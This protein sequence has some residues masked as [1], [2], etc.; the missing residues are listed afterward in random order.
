MVLYPWAA[1]ANKWTLVDR[2]W[3]GAEWVWICM[4]HIY[5]SNVTINIYMTLASSK[6]VPVSRWLQ[7]RVP[8]H[9]KIQ[10]ADLHLL[11]LFSP[12]ENKQDQFHIWHYPWNWNSMEILWFGVAILIN[13]VWLTIG[14][15]GI[16]F[17]EILIVIQGFLFEKMHLNMSSANW[18]PF[19]FRPKCVNSLRPSDAYMRR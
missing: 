6:L 19:L 11:K 8:Q 13:A 5:V 7:M 4:S 16:S 15:I 1:I 12:S 2:W 17:S 9:K 3:F 18:W 10:A 14:P